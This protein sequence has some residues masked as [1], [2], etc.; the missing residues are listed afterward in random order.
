M[1]RRSFLKGCGV[2][3]A[4]LV[5]GSFACAQ[6]GDPTGLSVGELRT[7]LADGRLIPESVLDAFLGRIKEWDPRWVCPPGGSS[8]RWPSR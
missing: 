2:V 6:P 8:G 4:T 5:A 1:R 3:G 7:G